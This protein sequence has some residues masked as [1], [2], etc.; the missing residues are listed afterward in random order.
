MDEKPETTNLGFNSSALRDVFSF[1]QTFRHC[2]DVHH[3]SHLDD[4]DRSLLL[5]WKRRCRLGIPNFRRKDGWHCHL[6]VSA[7]S[8]QG[9]ECAST[10]V[11]AMFL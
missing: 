9:Y 2:N 5:R 6:L 10:N 1:H 3:Q 8:T 11:S 4:E 7:L